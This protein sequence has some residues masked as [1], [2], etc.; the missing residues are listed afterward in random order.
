MEK[1]VNEIFY[2]Q[3]S[4]LFN[5]IVKLFILVAF[6]YLAGKAIGQFTY[7]VSH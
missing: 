7:N 5:R 6:M 1:I 3:N 4:I 2:S